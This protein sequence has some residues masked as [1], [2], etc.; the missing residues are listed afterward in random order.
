[1]T[2]YL[3]TTKTGK[4]IG[5]TIVKPGDHPHIVVSARTV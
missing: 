1:M 2:V 4:Y 3:L 5:Q